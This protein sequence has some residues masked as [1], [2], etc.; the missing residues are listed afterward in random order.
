M[1][2]DNRIQLITTNW[3]LKYV[4]VILPNGFDQPAGMPEGIL[5]AFVEFVM[6]SFEMPQA[7]EISS[8]CV[9]I[10]KQNE[11]RFFVRTQFVKF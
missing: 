9:V 7:A 1:K 6:S 8:F 10:K 11:N 3:I 5:I 2:N 4:Y